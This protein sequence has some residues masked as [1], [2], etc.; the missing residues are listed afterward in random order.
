MVRSG[1]GEGI[2]IISRIKL[3]CMHCSSLSNRTERGQV[4]VPRHEVLQCA[5]NL[6]QHGERGHPPQTVTSASNTPSRHMK[7]PSKGKHTDGRSVHRGS[8]PGMKQLPYQQ[9]HNAAPPRG[10]ENAG[11]P[12]SGVYPVSVQ[13]LQV[14]LIEPLTITHEPYAIVYIGDRMKFDEIPTRYKPSPPRR[15]R[16]RGAPIGHQR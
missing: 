16:C 12:M 11:H 8:K 13:T 3:N 7:N 1:K 2:S 4:P 5:T 10:C 6:D 15:R 9:G 14:S